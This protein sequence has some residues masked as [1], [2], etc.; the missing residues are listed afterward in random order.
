MPSSTSDHAGFES[1][2]A[3]TD[4]PLRDFPLWLGIVGPP[5]LWLTQ[6]QTIYMLVFP[7]C[8]Q[9]RNIIIIVT[10]LVFSV[11]IAICGVIAWTNR[12]PV[13]DSLVH[14]KR[15]RHFMAVLSILSMSIFLIVTLAQLIAALMISP[16]P[17]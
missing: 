14:V 6:F 9:H 5:L 3:A 17:I 7:A 10:S 2:L 4:R 8:G 11:A 13:A 16:C 15:A 1:E 12:V